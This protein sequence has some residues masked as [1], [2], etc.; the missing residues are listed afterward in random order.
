MTGI[1]LNNLRLFQFKAFSDFPEIF[2][3]STTREG[4]VSS[5][6]Y[7]SLNLGFKSGDNPK[8]VL[9]NRNLLSDTLEISSTRL[10]F[11]NQVHSKNVRVVGDDI[12]DFSEEGIKEFLKETDALI[13]GVKGICIAVKTADCVPVL[14]FDRKKKII[15]AIHAGWRGTSQEITSLTVKTMILEAGSDP[16]DIL[17]GIG[18]SISP[19]VYEVGK[20]VWEQFNPDFYH[21]NGNAD[22]N[23]KFLDL[24]KAN[25]SQLMQS[26]IPAA[27]IESAE[28][29][30]FSN[31][32]LFFSAR[33]DGVNTGRMATGIMLRN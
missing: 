3:F 28:L 6:R 23:K 7:H 31:S 1:L 30:T 22:S 20:E 26:G 12:K 33:R 17:A 18:P 4:G 10:L 16:N 14:L 13:T 11:P 9:E 8:E 2:H 21:S 27:N 15:A 24:W 32:S 29:C 19:A 25:R 5:G